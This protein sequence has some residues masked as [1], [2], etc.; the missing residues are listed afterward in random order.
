[1]SS[2]ISFS[3]STT[4]TVCAMEK[5]L[6][7]SDYRAGSEAPVTVPQRSRDN[8]PGRAVPAPLRG[9]VTLCII[10]PPH[11][12]NVMPEKT[13]RTRKRTTAPKVEPKASSPGAAN[14][15]QARAAATPRPVVSPEQRR[16]MIAEAAYFRALRRG[17]PGDPVLDWAEAEIEIDALL[18]S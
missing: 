7:K 16:H 1:M 12:R 17:V 11:R 2:T 5:L 18:L 3:S 4:R 14:V 9:G 8:R 15:P 13:P 6:R 10:G